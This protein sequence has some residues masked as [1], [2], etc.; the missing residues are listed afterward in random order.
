MRILISPM[1]TEKS[2][3]KVSSGT[4][5]FEV[6]KK[7]NK[8]QIAQAVE[9]FYKVKVE[10]INIINVASKI[11][12]VKGRFSAKRKPFKKAV[13]TLEKDQKIPGF[14]GK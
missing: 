4:Y 11:K 12:L 6:A 3:A 1:V 8:A 10:K 7:A 9:N 5:V 13:I 14:E 2:M